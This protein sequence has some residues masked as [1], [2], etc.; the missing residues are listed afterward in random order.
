MEIRE[1]VGEE[2]TLLAEFNHRLFNTLQIIAGGLMQ[3]RRD[4]RDRADMTSL[5]NLE[6]RLASLGRMHRLLSQPAPMSGLEDHCRALCTL[7]VLAFGRED[8]TIWVEMEDLNLT[9]EQA[10]S[11][12]LLVVELVTNVLK[13]SL[14]ESRNGVVWIDLHARGGEIELTVTDNRKAP[15]PV[16]PPSRIVDVL[17][18][19]LHG[20]AFVR[21]G[22]GWIAGARIPNAA[23]PIART[24]A[25]EEWRVAI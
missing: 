23:T 22:G 6:N 18:R 13:H 5:V 10:Y 16:F 20:E 19:G 9:P 2:I 11:L 12:P 25:R 24:S 21:D 1:A 8:V 7:L 17:A 15:M 4:L 3:C 14:A